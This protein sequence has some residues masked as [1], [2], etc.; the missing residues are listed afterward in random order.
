MKKWHLESIINISDSTTE[1]LAV[2]ESHNINFWPD[3]HSFEQRKEFVM[4]PFCRSVV[5]FFVKF[6]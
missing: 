2:P 5:A 6:F 1:K 3:A 4:V